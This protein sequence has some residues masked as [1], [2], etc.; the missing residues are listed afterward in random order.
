[1]SKAASLLEI[2]KSLQ[3]LSQE[4]PSFLDGLVL[5]ELAAEVEKWG[6]HMLGRGIPKPLDP[7]LACLTPARIASDVIVE[8]VIQHGR[9]GLGLLELRIG[10]YGD[11]CFERGRRS[12]LAPCLEDGAPSRAAVGGERRRP[13]TTHGGEGWVVVKSHGRE[14]IPLEVSGTSGLPPLPASQSPE[15]RDDRDPR[16]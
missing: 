3:A 12:V 11:C 4:H 1:M 7:N 9:D 14:R 2:A 15:E 13:G 10:D 8:D 6:R 5:R 16:R